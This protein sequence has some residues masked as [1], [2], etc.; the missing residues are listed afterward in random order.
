VL[1]ALA[2][3]DA[4]LERLAALE[5]TVGPEVRSSL[6]AFAETAR[7]LQS[8]LREVVALGRRSRQPSSGVRAVSMG[9]ER[10]GFERARA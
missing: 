9:L 5:P 10:M 7:D 2:I 3:V 8:T 1:L 6:E 4:R